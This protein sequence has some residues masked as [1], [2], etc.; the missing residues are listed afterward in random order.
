MTI[1]PGG[2]LAGV[3][4]IDLSRVLGGPYGTQLLGDHGADIIKVE[5]PQGDETRDWGPPF[6]GDASSYFTGIN[7]N[8]RSIGLDLSHA[9]GRDALLRL[10]D[11][12]DV[13]VENFKTGT[14]EK[15][16]LG[17]EQNL[18]TRFPWGISILSERN[19]PSR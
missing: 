14:L 15:W 7:R 4:I 2:A 18:E 17:Y 16:G 1:E 19:T 8:K 3:R 11:G 13:L 5:P 10:L 9:L 6:R 12:A